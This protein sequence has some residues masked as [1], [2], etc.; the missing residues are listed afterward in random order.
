MI[1]CVKSRTFIYI[2]LVLKGEVLIAGILGILSLKIRY[3]TRITKLLYDVK[4]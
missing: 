4:V 3:P 2:S 1:N